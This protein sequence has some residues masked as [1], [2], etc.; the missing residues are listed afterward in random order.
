MTHIKS[1]KPEETAAPVAP[2]EGNTLRSLP[3][4]IRR[5][6]VFCMDSPGFGGS[7]INLLR[8]LDATGA[9]AAVV[10]GMA[11]AEPVRRVL[12]SKQITVHSVPV[13]NS[14]RG[15]PAGIIQAFRVLRRLPRAPIVVWG[16]HSDS[17]RWLQLALAISGRRFVIVE[18][19][20]PASLDSFRKSRLSKPIKRYVANRAFRVVLLAHTQVPHYRRLFGV[21]GATLEVIRNARPVRSIS[22]GSDALRA[23]C[24]GLAARLGLRSGPVVL[25]VAR[26]ARDKRLEDL[27]QGF[28]QST[29]S[30]EGTLVLVGDGP[31]LIRLKHVARQFGASR[32]VFAGYQP[33]PLPWLAAADIFVLPS[34]S[35]GLPG[36]L[37]EAMAA[38]IPCIATDIPGNQDLVRHGET[39]LLCPVGSP[40]NIA[41][42]IDRLLTEPGLSSRLA[43]AARDLVFAEFDEE[44]EF[45]AWNALFQE[46]A[47]DAALQTQ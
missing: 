7:E 8:I 41:V 38:G 37:I 9:P 30:R 28:A 31:E 12:A 47:G 10:T 35:E 22:V 42:C 34:A 20:V 24:E 26:L 40:S 5:N 32:I 18:Q 36:V 4:G 25:A 15:A 45:Q 21:E 2:E 39:G 13:K 1:R 11:L 29:A 16:H 6:L 43:Q 19:I 17:H 14:W 46:L 33:D 27:I 23:D 44:Q 3:A